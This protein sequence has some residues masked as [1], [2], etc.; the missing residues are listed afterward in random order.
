[1]PRKPCPP[2]SPDIE[3]PED[4]EEALA[5]EMPAPGAV[6]LLQ[7]EASLARALALSLPLGPAREAAE[8]DAAHLQEILT[9]RNR[10]AGWP[11]S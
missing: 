3:K 8:R 2:G 11:V 6:A 9:A 7:E 10:A 5:S 1:M 4:D